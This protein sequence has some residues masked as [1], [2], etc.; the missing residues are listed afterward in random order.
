M[1]S[2]WRAALCLV[3]RHYGGRADDLDEEDLF[4]LDGEGDYDPPDSYIEYDAAAYYDGPDDY[5]DGVEQFGGPGMEDYPGE[6]T[7]ELL[8]KLFGDGAAEGEDLDALF[9]QLGLGAG[10]DGVLYADDGYG[11]AFFDDEHPDQDKSTVKLVVD[12]PG[13][14]EEGLYERVDDAAD[15]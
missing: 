3:L 6:V 15:L 14:V 2:A 12:E 13:D 5:Y 1:R 4:D 10:P 8:H 9:E 7:P 11:E